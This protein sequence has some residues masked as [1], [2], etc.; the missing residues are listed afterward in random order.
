MNSSAP[1]NAHEYPPRRKMLIRQ[2]AVVIAL[3]TACVLA[4]TELFQFT[5]ESTVDDPVQSPSA[6]AAP[7][8][9][10]LLIKHG[11]DI[12]DVSF[13]TSN[14]K[15]MER[16]P[17]DGVVMRMDDGLS[18]AVQRQEP[19]GHEVFR[20]ALA[21]LKNADLKSLKHNFLIV[22]STP[23]G[24]IFDNWSTP[25]DNYS[26]MA[27]AASATD[28][29]G[30][31]FDNEEYFGSALDEDDNCSGERTIDQCRTQAFHRGHN[32]MN[33]I[34]SSWPDAR[35]LIARGPYISAP[36][37]AD[38]F[39]KKG[40]EFNDIARANVLRGDFA[41]GMASATV[42]K[43][44]QYID[45]GQVYSARTIQNFEDLRSWQKYGSLTP[46]SLIP[47]DLRPH[48]PGSTSA[49]FGV[50]DASTSAPAMDHEVWGTTLTN[51]LHTTDRYVW[52]YTE[53]HDW[54]GTGHPNT[55]VP[56]TWVAAA[57]QA[58]DAAG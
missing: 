45:G 50:Y 5:P 3:A 32:V 31:F 52:A 55:S 23:A 22:Y 7:D 6:S 15:S 27:K 24:D 26:N 57:R 14:A 47:K 30:I 42:G 44:A 58:R 38:H 36:E 17:F 25:L 35:I 43:N 11:W 4:G 29:E 39:N 1:H 13:V 51:A 37:T 20:N 56:S 8:S 34:L 18:S 12:P 48:W 10:P 33:A 19:V 49:A 53:R 41:A 28:L 40:M 54:W 16:M 2:L 9:G 21:P 46:G